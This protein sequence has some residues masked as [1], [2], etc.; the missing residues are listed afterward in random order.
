LQAVWILVVCLVFVALQSLF[1]VIQTKYYQ[2]HV[3]ELFKRYQGRP[4]SKLYTEVS[5]GILRRAIV[6]AVVD[7]DNTVVDCHSLSGLTV[8][9]RFRSEDAYIGTDISEARPKPP[10]RQRGRRGGDEEVP[11]V[12]EQLLAKIYQRKL[13]EEADASSQTTQSA[14]P[15]VELEAE[16]DPSEQD[17]SPAAAEAVQGGERPA[18]PITPNIPAR[19]PDAARDL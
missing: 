18:H 5:D 11:P 3:K 4:G 1:G 19:I 14:G 16:F 10:K 12:V 17:G 15:A 9:A 8:F 13:A 6:V 7:A 2:R